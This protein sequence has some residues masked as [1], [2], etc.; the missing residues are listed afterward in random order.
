MKTTWSV[1]SV[2]GFKQWKTEILQSFKITP[3]QTHSRVLSVVSVVLMIEHKH[4]QVNKNILTKSL[5]MPFLQLSTG[6]TNFRISTVSV[7][8]Q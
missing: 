6:E 2:S 7:H 8:H 5:F 4:E 3:F 1:V